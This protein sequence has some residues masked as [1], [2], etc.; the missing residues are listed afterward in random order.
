MSDKL[1][2]NKELMKEWDYEKNI[3]LDPTKLNIGSGKKAWWICSSCGNKW[4]T[5][6]YLRKKHGCPFCAHKKVG[7]ANAKIKNVS[8]SLINKFPDVVKVWNYEKNEGLKPEDFL[9]QS[10]KKVWWKCS[11]CG[12]EWQSP[13]CAKSHTTICKECTY[14]DNKR[15]YVKEG[16]NE[17]GS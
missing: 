2:N 12:K 17:V 4:R 6:I 15:V 5:Q 3:E 8:N 9:Y 10:N 14:K 11:K 7:L 13:I 1:I 16:I